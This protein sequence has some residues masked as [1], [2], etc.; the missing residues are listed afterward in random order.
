MDLVAHIFVLFELLLDT[1]RYK[2]VVVLCAKLNHIH[3][4]N[5]YHDQLLVGYQ[6]Q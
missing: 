4:A 2:K 3:S 6:N 5:M 1:A